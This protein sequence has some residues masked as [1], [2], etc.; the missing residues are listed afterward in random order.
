MEIVRQFSLPVSV[1]IYIFLL[2]ISKVKLSEYGNQNKIG[3]ILRIYLL[4]IGMVISPIINGVLIFIYVCFYFIYKRRVSKQNLTIIALCLITCFYIFFNT[5]FVFTNK[6]FDPEFNPYI[7]MFEYCIYFVYYILLRI[8]KYTDEEKKL[9]ISHTC[10][11]AVGI[12]V[13]LIFDFSN[14]FILRMSGIFKNPNLLGI[15]SAVIFALVFFNK[16]LKISG[17]LRKLVLISS[18]LMLVLSFSRVAWLGLIAYLILFF[19]SGNLNM[20][21]KI[22]AICILGISA[23]IIMLNDPIADMVNTRV[24]SA[25]NIRDYSTSDRIVLIQ[26]AWDS[27]KESPVWGN[28]IR[29]FASIIKSGKYSIWSDG[30]LHPHNA[31]FEMLQSLGL[32]GFSLFFAII[33]KSIN[34]KNKHTRFFHIIVMFLVI[35]LLNRLFNEFSTSIWFWT[36][37]SFC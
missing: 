15:Y 24:L 11:F 33:Y 32:I 29:S 22:L 3:V 13:I 4:T 6:K 18:G 35:G 8:E 23:L 17:W 21:S 27:F 25:F 12:F 5:L 26:A 31:Y 1:G 37:L 7:G 30:V 19:V 34:R 2:C 28:G 36:I 9:L 14:T 20:K 10:L 16:D